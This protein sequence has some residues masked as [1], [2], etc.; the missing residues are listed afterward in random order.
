LQHTQEAQN[1]TTLNERKQ[2]GAVFGFSCFAMIRKNNHIT[3]LIIKNRDIL[4]C[5][6]LVMVTLAVYRQVQHFDFVFDDFLYIVENRHVQD[7]LT[8]DSVIWACTTTHAGNWHPLTWLSHML[9]F[10]IYG[11]NA[12]GHHLISLFFHIANTLLL[13]VVFNKMTGDFRQSGFV[14]VLFALHPLHVESVAWVAERKDV[15]STFFWL[16]TML[17]YIWYVKRP[18]VS[19]YLLVILFFALGLLAKPMLVTLPFVLLL[20]DYWPLCRYQVGQSGCFEGQAQQK[21][22][23]LGLVWEKIPFF[24]LATISCVV[25]FLAQKHE[26]YVRSLDVLPLTVRIANA[27]VSYVKYIGKMIWPTKMAVLY[28]HPGVF[29]WWKIAG[30]FL[31]LLSI[32][33]LIIR[34]IKQNPCFAVGWLWY[35]GT[36]VPVIGLVQ[37]GS[38]SM[39]DRYTYVPFIGLFIIIAW[40]VTAILASRP[41]STIGLAALAIICLPVLMALTGKQLGYWENN[42]TLFEHTLEITSNNYLS[43]YNL[44]SALEKQGRTEEAIEHYLKALRIRPGYVDAYNN[45]GVSLFSKRDVKGA[46]AS[47]REA[48]RIKPDYSRAKNNLEKVLMIQQQNQRLKH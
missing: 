28:P 42:I 12:G 5:L 37:V 9:D 25:T 30:A 6:F 14:A 29:P 13:F 17:S 45:L 47:F 19:K 41:Y 26:G 7:G 2:K 48:L 22:P 46:I 36:F 33:L 38:Q 21:Q 44:G 24:V 39:A 3:E 43:H 35:L 15:L 4:T 27:L 11:L 10:K 1:S 34:G 20:L 32:S 8:L 18:E 23:A 16:L 31:L 40:G